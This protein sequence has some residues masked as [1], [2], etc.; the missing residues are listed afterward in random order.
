MKTLT[1]P[2]FSNSNLKASRTESYPVPA[3]ENRSLRRSDQPE[4]QLQEK[5][6][7]SVKHRH[8][9]ST[10]TAT[11]VRRIANLYFLERRLF[12]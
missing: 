4:I 7:R 12:W 5:A 2:G 8:Q 3:R 1:F 9:T 10:A 11:S 6:L